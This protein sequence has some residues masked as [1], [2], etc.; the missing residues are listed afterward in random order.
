LELGFTPDFVLDK[1]RELRF[2]GIHD[3]TRS[4]NNIPIRNR[5]Q[6]A[7]RMSVEH[8]GNRWPMVFNHDCERLGT[9]IIFAGGTPEAQA[10]LLFVSN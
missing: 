7:C 10:I 1:T 8:A 5:A 6:G 2:K 3:G 9:D 4:N